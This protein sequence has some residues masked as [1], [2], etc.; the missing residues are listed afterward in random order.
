MVRDELLVAVVP[1]GALG[2]RSCG[3]RLSKSILSVKQGNEVRNGSDVGNPLLVLV[4]VDA[5]GP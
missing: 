5:K 3:L 2:K 4:V 1:D